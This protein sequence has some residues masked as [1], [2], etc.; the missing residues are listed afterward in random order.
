MQIESIIIKKFGVMSIDEWKESARGDIFKEI[1]IILVNDSHG[2]VI[3]VVSVDNPQKI[4]AAG[5]IP[6]DRLYEE[7]EDWKDY[8][9]I[10]V[11][12]KNGS[13]IGCLKREELIFFYIVI[14]RKRL[15]ILNL[16]YPPFHMKSP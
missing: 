1:D 3:G 12:D 5:I 4:L 9:I 13:I 7:E 15:F 6:I 16:F 8:S 2:Q 14:L 10:I 11:T